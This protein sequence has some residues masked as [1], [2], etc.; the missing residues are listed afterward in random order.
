MQEAGRPQVPR[1]TRG[2]RIRRIC[3][4][5]DWSDLL[6]EMYMLDC[7]NISQD[8]KSACSALNS[9]PRPLSD[10][11]SGLVENALPDCH[12]IQQQAQRK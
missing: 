3:K 10:N 8:F 1:Q 7:F 6:P 5:Y 4:I 12:K 11:E 9:E 2:V